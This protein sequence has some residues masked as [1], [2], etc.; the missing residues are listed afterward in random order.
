MAKPHKQGLAPIE[1]LKRLIRSLTHRYPLDRVYWDFVEM[2]AIA[3]GQPFNGHHRAAKEERYLKLIGAY[4]KEGNKEQFAFPEMAAKLTLAMEQRTRDYLGELASEL[5]LLN[6]CVTPWEIACLM[7][8]LTFGTRPPGPEIEKHGFLTA[9]DLCCGSGVMPLAA[10]TTLRDSGI[11]FQTSVYFT[12]CDIDPRCVHMTFLQCA[13]IGLPA[14]VYL[15]DSL[16]SEFTER[17]HTPMYAI[18]RWNWRLKERGIDEANRAWWAQQTVL[19]R[20]DLLKQA[21]RTLEEL[22]QEKPPAAVLAKRGT[23]A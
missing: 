1:E 6:Q 7:A 8:Q 14:T 15:G 17:W 13:L 3:F 5:G 10:A 9:A 20:S 2:T 19:Q 11:N 12:L 23:A 22:L 4:A 18:G 16:Q 21:G